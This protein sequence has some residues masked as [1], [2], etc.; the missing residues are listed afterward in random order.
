MGEWRQKAHGEGK[1]ASVLTGLRSGTRWGTCSRPAVA[2]RPRS[3]RKKVQCKNL[4]L[5]LGK[6]QLE[7]S[8]IMGGSSCE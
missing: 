2:R 4:L 3:E 1:S 8:G 7:R 6:Q 5:Q